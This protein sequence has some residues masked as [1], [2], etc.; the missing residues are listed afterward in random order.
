[1]SKFT[2]V[3]KATYY[4]DFEAEDNSGDEFSMALHDAER[5]VREQGEPDWDLDN[6]M[7]TV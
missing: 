6:I 3:F 2:A 1:M 7:E 5:F 4:V